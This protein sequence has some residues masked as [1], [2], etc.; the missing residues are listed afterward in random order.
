M[1]L[2]IV[3]S[4]TSIFLFGE[5]DR[6]FSLKEINFG[7]LQIT[8]ENALKNLS[9]LQPE[10]NLKGGDITLKSHSEDSLQQEIA[11]PIDESNFEEVFGRAR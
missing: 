5:E 4:L 3:A 7:N 8:T 11:Y 6:E 1:P 2:I 9:R 10:N